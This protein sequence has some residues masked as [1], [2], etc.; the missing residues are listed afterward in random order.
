MGRHPVIAQ[1]SFG[2]VSRFD[3]RRKNEHAEHYSVKLAHGPF[4]LMKKVC[5]NRGSTA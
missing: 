1:E 2:Q 5:R 4:L 3:I